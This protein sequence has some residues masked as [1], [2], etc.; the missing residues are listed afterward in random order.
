MSV[1]GLRL[2]SPGSLSRAREVLASRRVRFILMK[3]F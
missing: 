1:A 2:H 3:I